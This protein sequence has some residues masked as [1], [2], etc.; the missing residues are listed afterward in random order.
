MQISQSC[1]SSLLVQF[2]LQ[3]YM[4][5]HPQFMYS[6]SVRD[7]KQLHADIFVNFHS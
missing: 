7:S 6:P 4:F 5:R 1:S 3:R 2:S